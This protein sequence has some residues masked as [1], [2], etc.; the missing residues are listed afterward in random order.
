MATDCEKV[1]R[2]M[3]TPALP[4]QF[5]QDRTGSEQEPSN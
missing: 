5:I 2:M 4:T 3:L 1:V